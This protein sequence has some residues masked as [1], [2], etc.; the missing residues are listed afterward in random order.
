MNGQ[1]GR[2]AGPAGPARASPEPGTGPPLPPFVEWL[3]RVW[4][5]DGRSRTPL[6]ERIFAF[7]WTEARPLGPYEIT[8]ALSGSKARIY[9]NSVYR[10]LRDFEQ[11]GLVLP[12][13]SL[14]RYIV[15]PDPPVRN[16][17]LFAC[18]ACGEVTAVPNPTGA[19]DLH[20]LCREQGFRP[21]SLVM[22]CLG[23]CG[24]CSA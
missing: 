12:I 2:P 3:R 9:P 4:P 6:R 5:V 24:N 13:A 11:A 10:V 7:L 22:E 15:S 14:K 1:A 8:K 16:W 17:A 20:A 23:L 21:Q 18:T 19:D